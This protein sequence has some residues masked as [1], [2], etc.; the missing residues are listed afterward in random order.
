[1]GSSHHENVQACMRLHRGQ[2][3]SIFPNTKLL[4]LFFD[5]ALSQ[6]C[7][8]ALFKGGSHFNEFRTNRRSA[9]RE[10]KGRAKFIPKNR[11]QKTL[12]L[13]YLMK[14]RLFPTFRGIL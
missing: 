10:E 5:E 4:S 7:S 2:C 12:K 8:L 11:R 6:S 14:N 3:F 9:I 13:V 1:M